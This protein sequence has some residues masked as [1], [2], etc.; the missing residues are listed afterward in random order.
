M[1]PV[2]L[3]SRVMEPSPL[4]TL[5]LVTED[6]VVVPPVTSTL[7]EVRVVHWLMAMVPV[8]SRVTDT[9]VR[10]VSLG[11]RTVRMVGDRQVAVSATG[12][13]VKAERSILLLEPSAMIW[14]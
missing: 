12:R 4:G 9:S 2:P 10:L 6:S 8:P 13:V 3:A 14:R 7:V 11:S 5:T 1:A